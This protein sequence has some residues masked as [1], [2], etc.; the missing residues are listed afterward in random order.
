M[1]ERVIVIRRE[2]GAIEVTV[3]GRFAGVM[4]AARLVERYALR[5]EKAPAPR[6]RGLIYRWL[7]GARNCLD[8]LLVG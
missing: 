2:S 5:Q 8:L 4:A 6:R 3:R 7:W 1:I